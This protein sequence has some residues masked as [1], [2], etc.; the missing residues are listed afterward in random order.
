MKAGKVKGDD[1]TRWKYQ[2]YIKDY[3]RCIQSVDDEVGRVLRWLDAQGLAENTIVVYSS[4]QGFYLGEHGWFDKR[5]MYE[6]SLKTPL[7]VRW[8]GVV[9]AGS[10]SEAM[11]SNIDFP[12]TFLDIA[13]VDIPADMQGRSLLPI[14]RGT[15]PKDWRTAFYYHYYEGPPM[16]AA[17]NVAR[18]YGVR[19]QRYKLVHYYIDQEWELFDLEKD[20]YEMHSVYGVEEYAETQADLE[21]Q[22]ADL[23]RDLRVPEKDPDL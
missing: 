11:V 7:L 19:T 2:R 5:W 12:E 4:D 13:G 14:L 6:E 23:R 22:L 15:T 10:E 20:P 21:R 9:E 17:H 8:P 1:I 18:H 3:L 16:R